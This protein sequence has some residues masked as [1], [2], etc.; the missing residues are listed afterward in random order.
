MEYCLIL[1]S[2]IKNTE[3]QKETITQNFGL[4]LNCLEEVKFRTNSSN[5]SYSY[6]RPEEFIN[7][8]SVGEFEIDNFKIQYFLTPEILSIG[9]DYFDEIYKIENWLR[10]CRIPNTFKSLIELLCEF[11]IYEFENSRLPLFGIQK[12][13]LV[14]KS[15]IDNIENIDLAISTTLTGLWLNLGRIIFPYEELANQLTRTANSDG[16]VTFLVEGPL[17]HNFYLRKFDFVIEGSSLK[18]IRI[19]KQNSPNWLTFSAEFIKDY[20]QIILLF[21]SVQ[22][23]FRLEFI[24]RRNINASLEK[25]DNLKEDKS[26]FSIETFRDSKTSTSMLYQS[27]YL[28]KNIEVLFDFGL[29]TKVLGECLKIF[30]GIFEKAK[31]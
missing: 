19:E 7:N 15:L 28:S 16:F 18:I 4:T 25:F 29:N 24:K 31:N 9:H 2:T 10:L 21:V 3:L 1:D 26:L 5:Y 13:H 22:P 20:Y 14:I 17:S 11:L 8:K 23:K 27:F 6:I 12:I 30:V